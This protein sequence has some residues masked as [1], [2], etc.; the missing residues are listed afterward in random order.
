MALREIAISK[1][2]SN[3]CQIMV[4]LSAS[5]PSY[6]E[7]GTSF[8]IAGTRSPKRDQYLGCWSNFKK[9]VKEKCGLEGLKIIEG[10]LRV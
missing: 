4:Q 8:Y 10:T 2:N 1:G 7:L 3:F 5:R 9:F 6:D